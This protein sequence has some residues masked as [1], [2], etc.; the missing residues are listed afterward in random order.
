MFSLKRPD[1]AIALL[2]AAEFTQVNVEPI[3]TTMRLAGGETV[4]GSLEFLLGMGMVRGLI[5]RLDEGARE[6]AIER[7][8]A[9]LAER[10][11]PGVGVTLGAAGYLVTARG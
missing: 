7:I 2:E 8:R 1:E 4:E 9:V 11:E 6:H 10:Y 5:N 3:T